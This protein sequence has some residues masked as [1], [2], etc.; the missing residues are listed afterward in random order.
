MQ[1][2]VFSLWWLFPHQG[3]SLHVFDKVGQVTEILM[4]TPHTSNFLPNSGVLPELGRLPSVQVSSSQQLGAHD[5]PRSQSLTPPAGI[6]QALP[7]GHRWCS[8]PLVKLTWEP[9]FSSN[10]QFTILLLSFPSSAASLFLSLSLTVSAK[11]GHSE[12]EQMKSENLPCLSL[13][14]IT[15]L[16]T[17]C[18]NFP[19]CSLS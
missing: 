4:G 6:S 13:I 16:V 19:C 1:G 8:F 10:I 15:I 2:S 3:M 7:G 17:I 18:E 14:I 5:R 9:P 11:Q 12:N